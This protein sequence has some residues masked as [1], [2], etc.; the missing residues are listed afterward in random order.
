MIHA[1]VEC[2]PNVLIRTYQWRQSTVLQVFANRRTEHH[3]AQNTLEQ[4]KKGAGEAGFSE[5]H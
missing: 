5:V 2:Y 3:R 1:R 4:A